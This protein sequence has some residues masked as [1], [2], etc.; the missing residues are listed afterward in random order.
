VR[1]G[2]RTLAEGTIITIDGAGGEIVLGDPG[3]TTAAADRHL[4]RL[5][6]W[7]SGRSVSG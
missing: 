2:D 6:E 5:L 4:D 1:S 7:A 3:T